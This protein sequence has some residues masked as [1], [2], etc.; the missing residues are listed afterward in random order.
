MFFTFSATAGFIANLISITVLL[1]GGE[2]HRK[3]I[4]AFTA[5]LSVFIAI[6]A[7]V[8]FTTLLG[9]PANPTIA[10]FM[11]IFAELAAHISAFQD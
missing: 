1:T 3:T 7:S 11:I 2:V 5:I 4:H 8:L 9:K 10:F 6:T